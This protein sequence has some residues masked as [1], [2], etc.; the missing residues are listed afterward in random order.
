MLR[1]LGDSGEMDDEGQSRDGGTR[2]QSDWVKGC[3]RQMGKALAR[4]PSDHGR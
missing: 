4:T 1:R 2:D 3:A